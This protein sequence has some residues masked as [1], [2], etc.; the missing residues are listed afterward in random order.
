MAMALPIEEW[1][2]TCARC[3]SDEYRI[4]GYCTVECRDLAEVEA[5]RDAVQR[6][7]AKWDEIAHHYK[8]RVE[9]LHR[10]L[11]DLDAWIEKAEPELEQIQAE[12]REL[13]DD[14]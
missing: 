11:R 7:A 14:G 4:D 6:N 13:I 3:G 10:E 1:G 12:I 5:E 9:W 2:P 8:G